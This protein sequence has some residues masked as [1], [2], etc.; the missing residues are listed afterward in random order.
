MILLNSLTFDSVVGTWRTVYI[1]EPRENGDNVD[2]H[3]RFKWVDPHDAENKATPERRL[4]LLIHPS[5]TTNSDYVERLEAAI[6]AWLDSDESDA[7]F[8]YDQH[9]LRERDRS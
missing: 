9:F 4:R 2:Y 7:F 3:I 8:D 6:Y 1:S 5:Q